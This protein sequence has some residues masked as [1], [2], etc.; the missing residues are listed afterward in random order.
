MGSDRKGNQS[1]GCLNRIIMFSFDDAKYHV[2]E[3]GRKCLVNIGGIAMLAI[4]VMPVSSHAADFNF[5]DCSRATTELLMS[6]DD[7]LPN[8]T[9]NDNFE[10]GIFIDEI[11][12]NNEEVTIPKKLNALLAEY[13][14]Y[15][16]DWDG[17]GA[18]SIKAKSIENVSTLLNL[19][20]ENRLRFPD[21]ILPT[22]L[23]TLCVE[24]SNG[25]HGS[26]LNAEISH[27]RMAFY[28]D[29]PGDELKSLKPDA[30]NHT[31]LDKLLG[32]VAQL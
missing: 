9:N 29:R 32:F 26:L 16:N 15:E 28:F 30:F 25:P 6:S 27:N 21:D 31:N 18:R 12:N 10:T 3:A 7:Y 4:S 19:I 17:E 20:K 22:E 2:K 11:V 1:D 13:A 24:W 23:G 5:D 14:E 8:E